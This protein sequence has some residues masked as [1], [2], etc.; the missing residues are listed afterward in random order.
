MLWPPARNPWDLSRH[1]GG[2]SSGSGAAVAAGFV[3]LA[4]GTDTGGSIRHPAGACGIVGL[5]PTYGRVSRRG[6]F[7]LSPPLD[8]VGPMARTVRDIACASDVLFAYDKL[9]PGSARR[10]REGSVGSEIDLSLKG[11]RVGF[12][13]HFHQ[14]DT[15]AD[16]EVTAALENVASALAGEG[17][18]VRDVRLLPLQD[19]AAAA[20]LLQFCH[21]WSVHAQ[22]LCDRPQDYGVIARQRI[23]SGAFF[24]A[25]DLILANRMRSRAIAAVQEVFTGC[26]ILLCANSMDPPCRINEPEELK[27]TLPRQARAPFS[28][29]GHPAIGM[30]AGM[31]SLGVPLS[32]QF[33]GRYFDEATVLRVA[34]KWECVAGTDRMHPI[35]G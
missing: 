23:M 17:A 20:M 19:M 12:I 22:W 30:S 10:T 1:P 8:H 14:E 21:A 4:L 11:L 16:H 6:V 18:D 3:P 32:L 34:R 35:L 31:S 26:D 5:K 28:L 2:S 13:R 27:R 9:D 7:P 24:S 29:T 25:S 15:Q 33:V